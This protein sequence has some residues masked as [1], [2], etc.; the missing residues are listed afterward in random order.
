MTFEQFKDNINFLQKRHDQI[1]AINEA[2]ENFNPDFPTY[3]PS[4]DEMEER[5]VRSM[6]RELDL[7]GDDTLSYF[8]Y[9]SNFGRNYTLGDVREADDTPIPLG[10]V[11]EVW[12]YIQEQRG[13][14]V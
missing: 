4:D 13:A 10:T 5:L 9:D 3:F 7:E 1:D 11:E 8:I 6:E 2:L 12:K 14:N